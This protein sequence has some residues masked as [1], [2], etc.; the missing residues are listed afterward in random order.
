[1]TWSTSFTASRSE[2]R[3][4]ERPRSASPWFAL[5]GAIA[6]TLAGWLLIRS[7]ATEFRLRDELT[8][9]ATTDILTGLP[10]RRV[11]DRVL[12]RART[13]MATSEA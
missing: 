6:A 7:R 10:N 8:H 12:D 2:R 13:D 9:Q 1:M 3:G 11:L 4:R 5:L